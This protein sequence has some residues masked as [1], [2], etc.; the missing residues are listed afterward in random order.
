MQSI[1]LQSIGLERFDWT[2][3]IA[4]GGCN[5][6]AATGGDEAATRRRRG[7]D[8]RHGGEKPA[9]VPRWLSEVITPKRKHC[10]GHYSNSSLW[11][12]KC[13]ETNG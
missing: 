1:G 9:V 5:G 13:L 2:D 6:A 8:G 11:T 10:L 7:G 12:C 4:R 3:S